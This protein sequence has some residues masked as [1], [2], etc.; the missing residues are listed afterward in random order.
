MKLGKVQ[1]SNNELVIFS[2]INVD[3]VKCLFPDFLKVQSS[4]LGVYSYL[5]ATVGII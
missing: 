1:K 5:S 3:I 2:D 4:I